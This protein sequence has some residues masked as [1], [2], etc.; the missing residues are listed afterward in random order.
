MLT[1]WLWQ[2]M[3][4]ISCTASVFYFS[5]LFFDVSFVYKILS[6]LRNCF[7]CM[8]KYNRMCQSSFHQN[9]QYW[10]V[11]LFIVI[12]LQKKISFIRIHW[13]DLLFAPP[14][15]NWWLRLHLF[16]FQK[17]D[18]VSCKYW[19]QFFQLSE[20]E[21]NKLKLIIILTMS[22]KSKLM[23][24]FPTRIRSQWR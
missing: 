24:K 12:P 20:S 19:K 4:S 11:S 13:C 22:L 7:T 2:W 8:N 3:V 5:F 17:Y 16:S 18:A 1:L 14:Y 23:Q 21:I 15:H 6:F 10:T 9:L